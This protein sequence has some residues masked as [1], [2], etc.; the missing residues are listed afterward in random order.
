MPH[1]TAAF[2][3]LI[4]GCGPTQE[5][6]PTV[7]AEEEC[8]FYAECGLL[9]AFAQDQQICEQTVADWEQAQLENPACTYSPQAAMACLDAFEAVTCDDF[10]GERADP[11]SACDLVCGEEP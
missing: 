4:I 2:V 8:A 5:R 1:S 6:W 7:R 3:G 10:H 9:E 11:V